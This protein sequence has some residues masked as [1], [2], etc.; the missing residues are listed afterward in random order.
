MLSNE[1]TNAYHR[2]QRAENPALKAFKEAGTCAKVC[3]CICALSL[4]GLFMT[5][6][7]Y[8]GKYAFSNPDPPNVWVITKSSR[9]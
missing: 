9:Y 5:F 1:M 4:G 7:I 8:L 6:W 2:E 3:A